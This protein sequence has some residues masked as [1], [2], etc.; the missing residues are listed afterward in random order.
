MNRHPTIRG[1]W[2][3]YVFPQLLRNIELVPADGGFYKT[4]AYYA[5]LPGVIEGI[6]MGL[7]RIPFAPLGAIGVAT[8][9]VVRIEPK[10]KIR[11]LYFA[12]FDEL[13]HIAAPV[14]R[15]MRYSSTEIGETHAIMNDACLASLLSENVE[16]FDEMRENLP[17]WTY[18]VC[19]SGR[20][21]EWVGIEE[22]TL[23]DISSGFRFEF[24]S[25]LPGVDGAGD[26]LLMDFERPSR[27]A[28]VYGYMP[29]NRIEFYSR[30][31]NIP[32]YDEIIRKIASK[33]GYDGPIGVF[34]LPLE[35]A[36]TCYVEYDL[37]FDPKDGE[38]VERMKRIL[39]QAYP[40]LIENG[41]F[42]TRSDYPIIN[43]KL[44]EKAPD[45]YRFMDRFCSILDPDRVF[46]PRY[47][48]L[49]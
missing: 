41:A 26:E 35:Q 7:D 29:H 30:L 42:F 9:G 28:R 27:V 49:S 11:K 33:D 10:L 1:S 8:K 43:E 19:C 46:N 39:S 13:K 31:V 17:P 20:D 4:G 3:T 37:Y 25:E 21:E 34:I 14:K 36:R 6:G 15:T 12:L 24:S 47:G 5:G 40:E 44:R 48:R 32:R 22:K 2:Q 23:S 16:K 18:A 38:H 45:Y